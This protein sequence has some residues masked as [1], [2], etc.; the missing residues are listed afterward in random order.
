[1]H[2]RDFS[3]GVCWYPEQWPESRWRRDAARMRELGISTVRLGEFAWSRLQPARGQW[4]ADWL[5]RA[6]DILHEN[7]LNAILGTPSAA[8]PR[9]LLDDFPDMLRVDA[10]GAQSA[11]GSRRF[12][13]LAHAGY[14]RACVTVARRLAREFGEHPA[15]VAWQ[16]DNEYA[17]HDTAQSWSARAARLFRRWLRRRYRD[18]GALNRAW[19]NAFWSMEYNNFGQIDPPG[20]TPAGNNPAH[21]LDFHRFWSERTAT[22]NRR[23]VSAVRRH[24]PRRAVLHDFMGFST[25][26]DHF[27]L[28][29]DLDLAAWN[30]Y[31]LGF[32]ARHGGG[33]GDDG[34]ARQKYLRLGAP[35]HA[36]FHH[37]LYRACGRGR[38]CVTEQQPGP[39]NWAAYNPQPTPAAVRFWTWEAFAHGAE[40]VSY[41]R[42]R[43][44]PRAQE[45]M[46][47]GLLR[48]DDQPAPS[49]AEVAQ[50]AREATAL[51]AGAFAPPAPAA[52]ALVFDY[53]SCWMQGALPHGDAPALA[54]YLAFYAALRRAGVD[55]DMV[56]PGGDFRGRRLV[57]APLLFAPAEDFA[58]R[59]QRAGCAAVF[60]ARCGSFTAAG[61]LEESPPGNLRDLLGL[62]VLRVE[63][64]PP[65]VELPVKWRDGDETPGAAIRWRETVDAHDAQTLATFA[66]GGGAVF[67]RG[68]TFYL[69]GRAN[70]ALL[71]AVV[72][73]ALRH[74]GV[75][76]ARPPADVRVRW[77]GDVAWL[78]NYGDA[79]AT[80]HLAGEI[81]LGE[82]GAI[83]PGG[84][85]ALRRNG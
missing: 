42:W 26:F 50:V 15:V 17:C 20:P 66:D 40:M 48:P 84:V 62:T 39:V 79:P 58:A 72:A 19:G 78:F 4:D 76:A 32:L 5:R 64:L 37:D 56:P 51:P 47:A 57:V 18:I 13:C 6:L 44:F 36:A 69:A 25:G 31:P 16:I 2:P 77:R 54:V 81:V 12:A 28:A 30:S 33:D 1:M 85:L 82:A 35:D 43:Q 24:S 52:V 41:F 3:L 14:A 23:Q 75:E 63:S 34:D 55:V 70:A 9:W 38:F 27:Q 61:A 29:A 53:E 22:F 49:A 68:D 46:H 83:P 11:F 45:M 73:R 67:A 65:T 80:P 7:G 10:A 21:I 60:G 59:L 8:P 71:D 74:A